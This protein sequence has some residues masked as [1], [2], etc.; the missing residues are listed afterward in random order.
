LLALALATFWAVASTV[1]L[2][3]VYQ[4]ALPVFLVARRLVPVLPHF[5]DVIRLPVPSQALLVRALA[6]WVVLGLKTLT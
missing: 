4:I 1:P 2:A 5:K 3:W 6:G